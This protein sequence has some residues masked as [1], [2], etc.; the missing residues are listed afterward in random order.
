MYNRLKQQR[1]WGKVSAD[2][3][4]AAVA[5]AQEMKV[6]AERG[7]LSDEEMKVA[8]EG[9]GRGDKTTHRQ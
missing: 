8:F 1:Y 6:R 5:E 7:D 9:M 4:N 2:E 3:W